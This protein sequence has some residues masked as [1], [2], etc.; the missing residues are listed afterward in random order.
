ME[1]VF[2]QLCVCTKPLGTFV[3]STAPCM[4]HFAAIEYGEETADT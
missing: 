2:F 4:R 3:V 1:T